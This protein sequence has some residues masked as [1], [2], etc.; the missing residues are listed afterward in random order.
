MYGFFQDIHQPDT[1]CVID[2]NTIKYDVCGTQSKEECDSFY[3]KMAER[4]GR[5]VEYLGEGKTIY[6]GGVKNDMRETH[7]FYRFK[8]L[9]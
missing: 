4:T 2:G 1:Y 8:N 3:N 9:K 6:V 5:K 7:H